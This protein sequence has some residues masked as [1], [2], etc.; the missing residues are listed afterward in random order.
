M[1]PASFLTL[2][3]SPLL[4]AVELYLGGRRVWWFGG[5]S[6]LTPTYV[7]ADDARH[8][9]SVI[10]HV[11]DAHDPAAPAPSPSAALTTAAGESMYGRYKGWCDRY[12]RIPHRN[13][14]RGI[15]GLFFDDLDPASAGMSAERLAAF[16]TACGDHLSAC[17]FPI[18]RRRVGQAYT[19]E[20]KHFQQLRR[21]RYVEFNLMCVARERRGGNKPASRVVSAPARPR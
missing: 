8:F 21:G 6:D 17:Y 14:A 20:Q 18:V 10:K 7:D 5:G 16:V 9:H 12:F 15:G 13:E 1:S 2:L 4:P 19:P 11:C 3:V